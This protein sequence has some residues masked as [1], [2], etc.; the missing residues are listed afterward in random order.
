MRSVLVC[1]GT[2]TVAQ[3]VTA[4]AVELDVVD[5][6]RVAISR[7]SALARLAERSADVIVIDTGLPMPNCVH[8]TRQLL[9]RCPRAAVVLVGVVSPQVAIAAMTAGAQA[10]FHA[11]RGDDDLGLAVLRG[12][13]LSLPG[14]G[15]GRNEAM[16]RFRAGRHEL[17]PREAEILHCMSQ[18]F[19]NA[20]IGERLFITEHTVKS[21]A[22]RLY[23]KLG[24]RDRAHAVACA[25]RVGA[26]R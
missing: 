11:Y 24:A 3:H 1:V 4:L 9:V 10:T 26:L 21:H 16:P 7:Q 22:R 19:N 17:T 13:L 12:I 23:R 6:V 20:E 8:F 5:A 2:P 15:R 18:G 14:S 25:L